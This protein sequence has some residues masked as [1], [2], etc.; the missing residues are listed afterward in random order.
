MKKIT[1]AAL[2]TVLMMTLLLGGCGDKKPASSSAPP[3]REAP[4]AA[5]PK[6]LT[7]TFSNASG[8]IFN[9]IYIS[10]TAANDWGDELLGSTSVLKSNGS[11]DVAVPAYDYDSYDIMVVDEDRDEYT[12]SRVPL[13][14]GSEVAIYFGDEGLAADVADSKGELS[15]TVIGD[16]NG[17]ST[18]GGAAAGEAP[19]DLPATVTGTGNDTNGQYSF[20]IYNESDFDIYAIYMGVANANASEDLDILPQVLPA[21]SSTDV[22]GLASQ[23]DW[24]NTEWTLNVVDVDGDGSLSFDSF[25]PWLVS[26]IDISW[27]STNGGYVCEFVYD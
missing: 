9:E 5:A 19:N 3:S 22:V 27:D 18:G 10:P 25:N 17:G 2:T 12:F 26:Y 6:E 16:I 21:G 7:V 13:Q 8:Y 15:S 14:N 4:S 24:M 1:C 20:T 23:G 11:L